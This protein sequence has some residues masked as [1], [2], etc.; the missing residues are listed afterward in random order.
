M[1]YLVTKE[2]PIEELTNYKD[3]VGYLFKNG[4]GVYNICHT[5][6]DVIKSN[7]WFKNYPLKTIVV[8]DDKFDV[9]DRFLA[10]AVNRELNGQVF[11][12]LGETK[13]AYE[14]IDLQDQK[15]NKITSTKLLLDGAYKFIRKATM[16]DKERLINGVIRE[17]NV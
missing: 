11:K 5:E 1:E 17:I 7:Q 6:E 14:L 9:G 16:E 2:I 15:G 13:D 12:Y 3:Y 10:C 4:N 8:S